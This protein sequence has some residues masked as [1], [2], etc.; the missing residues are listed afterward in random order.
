MTYP[1][2]IEQAPKI[3]EDLQQQPNRLLEEVAK[4]NFVIP[5]LI[6]ATAGDNL[7]VIELQASD[8]TGDDEPA[9]EDLTKQATVAGLA[10]GAMN[11]LNRPQGVLGGEVIAAGVKAALANPIGGHAAVAGEA[12]VAGAKAARSNPGD[13]FGKVTGAIAGAAAVAAAEAAA[14]KESDITTQ[15]KQTT[16]AALQAAADAVKA[17]NRK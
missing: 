12:A 5:R 4:T 3:S 9:S 10:A 6:E 2:P 15:T 14:S 17:R 8:T 1:E 13:A 7:P 16:A 11:A